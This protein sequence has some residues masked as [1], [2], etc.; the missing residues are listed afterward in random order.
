MPKD[1]PDAVVRHHSRCKGL[2]GGVRGRVSRLAM[3]K[4]VIRQRWNDK[5]SLVHVANYFGVRMYLNGRGWT[6]STHPTTLRVSEGQ[7]ASGGDKNQVRRSTRYGK[8]CRTLQNLHPTLCN[9]Y[10]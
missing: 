1:G 8:T 10:R 5:N 7:G 3:L 6:I 4:G 2:V 9:D